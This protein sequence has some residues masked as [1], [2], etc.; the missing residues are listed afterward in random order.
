MHI[1]SRETIDLPSVP[2][3][4]LLGTVPL[5]VV[6]AVSLLDLPADNLLSGGEE[7]VLGQPVFLDD[8]DKV[9]GLVAI[10]GLVDSGKVLRQLLLNLLLVTIVGSLLGIL[11]QLDNR[12]GLGV[13]RSTDAGKLNTGVVDELVLNRCGR[14]VLALGGLEDLLGTAGNLETALLVDFSAVTRLDV[15]IVRNG[16]LGRLLVLVVAHHGTGAL[17]LDL[18]VVRDAHVHIGVGIANVTGAGLSGEGQVRVVEVLRHT[19]ALKHLEA[20]TLVPR[21]KFGRDG[22]TSRSGKTDLVQTETLEDLLPHQ[23]RN[24]GDLEKCIQLLGFHLLEHTELE[25]GPKTGNR[26]EEGGTGAVQVVDEGGQRL[27]E[28]DA[29]SDKKGGAFSKPALHAVGK[30]KVGQ[31]AVL[32]G[33]VEGGL[34]DANGGDVHGLEV[35]HDALGTAGGAR[36]V[37]FG[38]ALEEGHK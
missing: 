24:D 13:R 8:G 29:V 27:G 37:C 1:I 5:I 23:V 9:H 19:I 20:D 36:G 11:G 3:D 38:M 15:A 32:A 34:V 6:G 28:V 12:M 30:G 21:Q 14:N 4:L 2:D 7:S 22:S 17:D 16:F 26:N 10:Q 25:L 35:V 31:V 18:S 33:G